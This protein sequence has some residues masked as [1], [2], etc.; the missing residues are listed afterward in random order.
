[1]I[2]MPIPPLISVWSE[3]IQ[4]LGFIRKKTK[5][6]EMRNSENKVLN[7]LPPAETGVEVQGSSYLLLLPCCWGRTRWMVSEGYQIHFVR[8]LVVCIQQKYVKTI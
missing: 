3:S 1:M 2:Q 5:T 4:Y 8:F 7:V 6:D